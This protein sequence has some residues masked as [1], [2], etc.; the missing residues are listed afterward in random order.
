LPLLVAYQA[1]GDSSSVQYQSSVSYSEGFNIQT[2]TSPSQ[3]TTNTTQQSVSWSG[4][5]GFKIPLSSFLGGS[6]G[7]GG[8]GGGGALGDVSVGLSGTSGQSWDSQSKYVNTQSN[9]ATGSF[10][11][12]ASLQTQIGSKGY[13]VPE[14]SG[15][16]SPYLAPYMNDQI[17]VAAHPQ[18]AVWDFVP[19]SSS[20]AFTPL[21]V[22]MIGLNNS[23]A[24][25]IP[26]QDLAACAG[27]STG[28][29]IIPFY[30]PP[31]G[32]SGEVENLSQADCQA[33][34][35]LDPFFANGQNYTPPSSLAT[36]EGAPFNIDL[37]GGSQALTI[38]QNA[39][40]GQQIQTGSSTL[41]SVDSTVGNSSS[42]GIQVNLGNFANG[43]YSNSSS[44]TQV[45]GTSMTISYTNSATSSTSFA[46][47]A[48]NTI[49]DD[50]KTDQLPLKGN[51]YFDNRFGTWMFQ[52]GMP[53]TCYSSTQNNQCLTPCQNTS[54]KPPAPPC[55]SGAGGAAVCPAVGVVGQAAGT[56]ATCGASIQIWG[57][58]LTG[59]NQVQFAGIGGPFFGH[60]VSTPGSVVSDDIVNASVPGGI[61]GYFKISVSGVGFTDVAVGTLSIDSSA[62]P[63]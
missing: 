60:A 58:G 50:G 13:P 54:C 19:A 20:G 12:S 55:S 34:L 51:Y 59:T 43:S 40:T 49:S 63:P 48:A 28:N 23:S 8:S 14:S 62:C 3:T 26:V 5:L 6:G 37:P 53:Q 38:S 33:L 7:S 2:G 42:F 29:T 4:G 25:L 56:V 21:T 57:T 47:S 30:T 17:L 61:A 18:F 10:G 44:S 36:S 52:L 1:P 27:D 35:L 45:A 31:P 46:E 24:G 9:S 16:Y 11:F 39:S 32:A 22:S 15:Q 41:S